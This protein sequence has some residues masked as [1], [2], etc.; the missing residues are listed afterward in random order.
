MSFLLSS[1]HQVNHLHLL[2]LECFSYICVF[3]SVCI[4][5][6]VFVI[7]SDLVFTI[8]VGLAFISCHDFFFSLLMF[9]F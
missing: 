3:I 2:F 7:L 6:I 5:H 9:L 1:A 8:S 4:C